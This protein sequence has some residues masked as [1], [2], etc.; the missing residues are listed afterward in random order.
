M[1]E[2]EGDEE[3][4]KM[5]DEDPMDTGDITPPTQLADPHAPSSS[6]DTVSLMDTSG[7]TKL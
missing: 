6:R 4:T 5:V 7:I 1:R 3:E 2:D